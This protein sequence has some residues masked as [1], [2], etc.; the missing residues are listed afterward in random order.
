MRIGIDL[1]IAEGRTGQ[2]RYLWEFGLWM[3]A[4]GHAM[5][6]LVTRRNPTDPVD[7]GGARV[8]GL[9]D[10]APAELV[11]RVREMTLDV[12]LINPER[13][14]AYDGIRANVL[15]PGYG[16]DQY[17]Q[18]LH[19]FRNPLERRVRSAL[20]KLPPARAKRER[21]RRFYEGHA[22]QPE[23]VAVS[24]YMRRE[25]LDSYR[26]DPDRVHV[27]P[28]GID[29]E[30]FS[31]ERR[32]ALREE[33]RAE[34]GIPGDALCIL[35]VAHNFRL[36]GVRMGME[37]IRRLRNAGVNAHLLVAGRGTGAVQRAQARGWAARMGISAATH[38]PGV[39]HPVMRAYAAADVFLHPSWHD[40]F[41]FVVLEAMGAGLPPLTSPW[42]GAS[43][44]V[45]EGRAGFVVDPADA[46]TV[47]RRLR[48]LADGDLRRRMGAEARRI[49]ERYGEEA[50][51]AQVEKVCRI[52]AGRQEGPVR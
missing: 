25:V 47:Y 41:G 2:Q 13:S 38:L 37:Q 40:S 32:A 42:A 5:E 51:F 50:N 30:T 19:S 44:L 10:L 17:R 6:L 7:A 14:D 33:V 24:E 52:A 9:A 39:V 15:R 36:K 43:M 34:F 35:F 12:L 22:P 45:D 8:H 48:E 27:V 16:T 3:A 29:L 1:R 11:P 21:E 26:I 31:P 4:R 46:G 18:K 28:N 49:A 23:V 20:R